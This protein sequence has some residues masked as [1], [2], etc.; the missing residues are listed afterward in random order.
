MTAIEILATIF[1]VLVLVK[2]LMIMVNPKAW[3]ALAERMLKVRAEL[4]ALYA[5][6][7][8]IIGYFIFS[9]LSIVQVAAVMLFT[10]IIIGLSMF[11]YSAAIM[12]TVKHTPATGP[13]MFRKNWLI[14]TIWASI[15]VWTL[16]AVFTK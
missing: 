9:S 8:V 11:Q 1:A 13:E 15:A 12:E 4:T 14:I 6:L 5:V 3:L 7:A 10:S 16:C 2:L